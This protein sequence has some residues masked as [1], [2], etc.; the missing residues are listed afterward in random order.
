MSK[1]ESPPAVRQQGRKRPRRKLPWMPLDVDGFGGQT[2]HLTAEETG[3]FIRLL[4]SMW[5]NGGSVPNDD[6]DFA[7][8]TR[9]APRRWSRV[10]ARLLPFLILTDDDRVTHQSIEHELARARNHRSDDQSGDQQ[11]ASDRGGASNE[12]K[13]LDATDLHLHLQVTESYTSGE[14]AP[15]EGPTHLAERLFQLSTT[16]P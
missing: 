14:P 3:A 7:R 10:K 2:D 5:R 11:C 8:V 13:G 1:K 16:R 6:K 15:S 12:T 4:L 9:V